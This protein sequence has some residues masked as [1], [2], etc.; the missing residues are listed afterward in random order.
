V[1]LTPVEIR[2]VPLGRA[3]MGY[4]RSTVDRMIVEIVESYEDVWRDRADLADRVEHLEQELVRYKEL[5]S[6]LRTTLVSAE[7]ASQ[8]LKEHA[9]REAEL[10]VAEAHAEART[11]THRA[12]AEREHLLNEARRIRSLLSAAL[13]ALDVEVATPEEAEA[14]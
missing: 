13:A 9:R 10:V 7:R 2:H 4:R 3:V 12:R 6:L 14:A 8:E 5:E 1:A 11:V